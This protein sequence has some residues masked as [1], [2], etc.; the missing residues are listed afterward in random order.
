MSRESTYTDMSICISLPHMDFSHNRPASTKHL[1]DF[2]D[3]Q[4]K[5]IDPQLA[6]HLQSVLPL[7]EI[8]GFLMTFCL[9]RLAINFLSSVS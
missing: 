9:L 7:L 3:L 6:A 8:R 4:L 5:Q 1:N 2:G